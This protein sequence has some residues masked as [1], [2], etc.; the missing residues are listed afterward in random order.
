MS[1]RK[2]LTE[3]LSKAL[4]AG[5]SQAEIGRALGVTRSTVHLW[6]SG[7]RQV[8]ETYRE[9]LR[10]AARPGWTITA[11]P[12]RTTK[13]GAP[14]KHVGTPNVTPLPSGAEHVETHARSAFARELDRLHAAGHAPDKF[15]VQLHGFRAEDSPKGTPART[16]RIEVGGLS[17]DEIRGLATG[18]KDM[19]EDVITRAV[20]ASKYTGGFTFHR[21]TRFSFD[22]TP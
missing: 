5:R 3:F 18:R 19:L 16:R 13:A 1:P 11:P 6:V 21:A 4:A 2:P 14:V 15:T 17:D 10:A 9:A 12:P 22:S 7:K 8:P 20:Q